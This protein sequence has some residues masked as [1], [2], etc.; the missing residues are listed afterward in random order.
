MD[1]RIKEVLDMFE[2]HEGR[3]SYEDFVSTG[4][5]YVGRIADALAWIEAKK[6]GLFILK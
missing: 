4:V 6:R 2:V 3:I 5:V 1:Y